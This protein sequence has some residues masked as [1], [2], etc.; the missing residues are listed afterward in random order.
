MKQKSK[1]T[2]RVVICTISL[3]C[4][5]LGT[6]ATKVNSFVQVRILVEKEED[7]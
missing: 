4:I 3:P 2:P 5:G 6:M 1:V 7:A